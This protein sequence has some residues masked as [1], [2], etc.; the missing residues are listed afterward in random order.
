LVHEDDRDKKAFTTPWGTFHYAKMLSSLKNAG[1]T[2]QHAMD[3]AFENEKDLFL[4]VYLDD[5]TV[6]SNLDEEHL[7]LL[8]IVFQRCKKYGISLN[9]KKSLFVMDE[10]KLLSHIISKEG[11]HI[12]PDRVEAIQ[13]IDFPCNKKDI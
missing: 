4:V 3:I 7:Y 9:P 5:L 13:K 10:G 2:F 12:D 11:I 8:K 1:A 6:F